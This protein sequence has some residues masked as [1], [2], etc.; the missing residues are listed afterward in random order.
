MGMG[1]RRLLPL[2]IAGTLVVLSGCGDS[3]T[4]RQLVGYQLEPPTRVGD[5]SL[6]EAETAES[7]SFK[8]DANE[9]LV[10]YFGFTACPD[11][12][13]TTLAAVRSALRT[14]GDDAS[15]ISLA[16]VTIDPQRD[17]ADVLPGYVRSFVADA[18]A[19]R[20]EDD[21]ALRAVTDRFG[22]S[23]SV[24]VGDDDKIEV[25]HTGSLYVVDEQGVVLDTMPFGVTSADIANDLTLLLSEVTQ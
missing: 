14:M 11:V 21:A 12:C 23:Y 19:L 3:E 2:M 9:L 24:T 13:P 15:R 22:A 4:P 16:M 25:A 5:L 1:I 10:V 18:Q 20:T 17:G 6:P 8:A 7:F